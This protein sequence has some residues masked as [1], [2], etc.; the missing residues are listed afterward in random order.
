LFLIFI[1]NKNKFNSRGGV[2]DCK[3][4]GCECIAVIP[5]SMSQEKYEW[6]KRYETNEIITSIDNGEGIFKGII[7]KCVELKKERKNKIV[8]F[9]QFEE[10]GNSLWHYEVTGSSIEH[11]FNN[12][13]K[14]NKNL[15]FAGYC[16]ATGKIKKNFFNF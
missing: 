13:K 1:L 14:E 5:P 6:L 12:L 15:N 16:S 8:I 11:I 3:L 7:D 10:F 4:L 9:N 2:L